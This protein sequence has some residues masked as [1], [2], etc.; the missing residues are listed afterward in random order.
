M[1]A[2]GVPAIDFAWHT[3]VDRKTGFKLDV[4]GN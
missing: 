2:S 3:L 4:A 1:T